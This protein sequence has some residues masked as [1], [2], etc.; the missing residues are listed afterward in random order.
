MLDKYELIII[1]GL[2]GSGKSGL[3]KKIANISD[4]HIVDPDMLEDIQDKS[5]KEERARKY[6][7]C[8]DD[9]IQNLHSNKIV[10]WCQPWR[11]M[12]RLL[13]AMQ[14]VSEALKRDPSKALIDIFIPIE[15]SWLRS[16]SKFEKNR[17]LFDR[18]VARNTL[19]PKDF[20]IQT[21]HING[22][23]SEGKNFEL[24][25]KFLGYNVKNE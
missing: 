11:R 25:C 13:T 21:L 4:A 2:P 7:I 14:H 24:V 15:I 18:Y 20:E 22:T 6:K 19:I 1:R 9:A 17:E 10:L 16:K 3:A 5:T 12:E 8:L 23:K